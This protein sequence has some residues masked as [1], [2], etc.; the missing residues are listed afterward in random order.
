MCIQNI[1]GGKLEDEREGG[2]V[3]MFKPCIIHDTGNRGHSKGCN[4]GVKELIHVK[5]SDVDTD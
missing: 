3:N 5:T 4:E 2:N 1:R